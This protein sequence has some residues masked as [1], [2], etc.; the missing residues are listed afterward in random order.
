VA[1]WRLNNKPILLIMASDDDL[2]ALEHPLVLYRGLTNA[3]LAIVPGTSHF[4]TQESQAYAQRWSLTS[5][6]LIR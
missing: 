1:A 2:I 4:L 6:A 3:E 5:S